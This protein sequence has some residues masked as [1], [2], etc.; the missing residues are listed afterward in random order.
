LSTFLVS[1][2]G[3]PAFGRVHLG[4][5]YFCEGFVE[6]SGTYLPGPTE[7]GVDV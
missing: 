2:A 3:L 1:A 7:P 6:A 5:F 4:K